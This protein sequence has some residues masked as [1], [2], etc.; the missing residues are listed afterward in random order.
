MSAIGIDVMWLEWKKKI[1]ENI[2]KKKSVENHYL[3]SKYKKQS[4]WFLHL[5]YK[6]EF[7]RREKGL[8]HDKEVLH[9]YQLSQVLIPAM[10]AHLTSN[11]RTNRFLYGK[12][13][14]ILKLSSV[15]MT[16]EHKVPSLLGFSGIKEFDNGWFAIKNRIDEHVLNPK[17]SK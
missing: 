16:G 13:R 17:R 3:L 2:A 5:R 1:L 8:D 6:T 9:K 10:T 12:G 7:E 11:A 4:G 15:L 14:I